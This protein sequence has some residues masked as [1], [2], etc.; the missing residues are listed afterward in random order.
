MK[1]TGYGDHA[2]ERQKGDYGKPWGFSLYEK[3]AGSNH[4]LDLFYVPP[5]ATDVPVMIIDAVPGTAEE[6]DEYEQYVTRVFDGIRYNNRSVK[7][8]VVSLEG[9]DPRG[10]PF[11]WALREK[12]MDKEDKQKWT[13][14][15]R[16]KR[17]KRVWL[18][19]CIELTSWTPNRGKNKGKTL[20]NFRRILPVPLGEFAGSRF[21]R[22]D[23]FVSV[24]KKL[25]GLRGQI[26]EVSRPEDQKSPKI[27][28]RW[29][30][31]EKMSEEEMESKFAEAA[32][33]HGYTVED[34]LRPVN[35][36]EVAKPMKFER[37][38]IQAEYIAQERGFS[39]D[40]AMGVQEAPADAAQPEGA[41]VGSSDA[42]DG[43][44]T[45]PF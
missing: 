26:F 20:S 45:I 22:E 25:S 8:A 31:G 6:L 29:W 18:L 30:P 11:A 24:A 40:D 38:R 2:Q 42:D 3:V 1:K 27:G 19:T 32:A 37:A 44:E 23:E 39:L 21:S 14:N 35:Y 10:C 5:G 12:E 34:F 9:V 16:P 7:N 13:G 15:Y 4:T 17:G 28:Q 36:H 33:Q 43:D 41:A